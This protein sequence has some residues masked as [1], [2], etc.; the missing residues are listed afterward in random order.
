MGG[1]LFFVVA[2]FESFVKHI[3]DAGGGDAKREGT[4][5]EET[6]SFLFF[7][8]VFK[9]YFCKCLAKKKKQCT[10]LKINQQGERDVRSRPGN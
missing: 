10:G 1:R 5:R 2:L 3:E 7:C 6:A 9:S 4:V 8:P